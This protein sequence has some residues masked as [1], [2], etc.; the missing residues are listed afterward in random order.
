MHIGRGEEAGLPEAT[1]LGAARVFVGEMAK[2]L[3]AAEG[4][5]GNDGGDG[6]VGAD[7]QD[8]V[9]GTDDARAQE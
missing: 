5:E 3:S 1:A 8:G 2:R 7:A 4:K 9:A 6:V